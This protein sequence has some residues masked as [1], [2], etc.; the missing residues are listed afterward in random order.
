MPLSHDVEGPASVTES[1]LL[2]GA[3]AT[4]NGLADRHLHGEFAA[5]FLVIGT[6]PGDL[7]SCM[8]DCAEDLS[9]SHYNSDIAVS[10]FNVSERRLRLTGLAL[11]SDY[12]E[13]LRTLQYTNRATSPNVDTFTIFVSDGMYNTSFDLP[14]SI[15]RRRRRSAAEVNPDMP[16]PTSKHIEDK[17]VM[18]EPKRAKRSFKSPSYVEEDQAEVTR[19]FS[20]WSL[21]AIVV[22]VGV[23]L[24]AAMIWAY[25]KKKAGSWDVSEA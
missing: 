15:Q 14:V 2:I 22:S 18:E 1:R 12:E 17:S 20:M 21:P 4:S 13:L 25:Q 10:E 23:I 16:L 9:T 3:R 19:G 11:A 5:T 24:A 6:P 8:V 7:S